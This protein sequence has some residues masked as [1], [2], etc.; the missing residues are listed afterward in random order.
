[1]LLLQPAFLSAEGGEESGGAWTRAEQ[2]YYFQISL[3]SFTASEEY[4]PAGRRRLLFAD[5][6][7]F[8][9][10][11]FGATDI[12][13]KGELGITSWLTA[14]ASTEYKVAVREARYLPTGRDSTASA[15]GLGD[16][17]IGT[18]VGLLPAGNVLAASLALNWKVPLA[19][20][21]QA[22][23]LGTG[24]VEYE[25]VLA[26][27][28]NYLLAGLIDGHAQVSAAY[29]LRHRGSDELRYLAEVGV[30]LL[31]SVKLRGVVDGVSSLADLDNSEQQGVGASIFDQSFTRASL[32]LLLEVDAGTE[33]TAGYASVLRGQNALA[34]SSVTFGIAWLR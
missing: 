34:G 27:G 13:F 28:S 33:L 20:F 14:V 24:V 12:R 21:T 11:N 6:S 17:W 22:I 8:S 5:S 9:D 23:P 7:R 10:G 18:R 15:S 4:D 29:R 19:S 26:A 25:G 32:S 3:T 2:G 16:L 31:P 30:R 1:M